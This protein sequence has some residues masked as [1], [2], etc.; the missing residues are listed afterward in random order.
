[1]CAQDFDFAVAR[2]GRDPVEGSFDG[3]AFA[4]EDLDEAVL[5]DEQ[6]TADT[7][8]GVKTPRSGEDGV[9]FGLGD[10][11]EVFAGRLA[12]LNDTEHPLEPF[13]ACSAAIAIPWP[14]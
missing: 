10:A 9:D 7:V 1:M 5:G 2:I 14:T 4:F 3:G 13:T 8:A 11:H 6:R 12:R